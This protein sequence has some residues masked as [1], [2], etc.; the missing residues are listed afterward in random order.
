MDTKLR[1][2][3][4]TRVEVLDRVKAILVDQLDGQ[5]LPEHIDPD[6]PLIGTGLAFDSVDLLELVLAMDVQFGL[7]I[8]S[9]SEGHTALRTVNTLV[10]LIVDHQQRAQETAAH[11]AD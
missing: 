8:P 2:R 11:A 9:G 4:A 5:F 7:R 3:I 6:T 1:D 10:D